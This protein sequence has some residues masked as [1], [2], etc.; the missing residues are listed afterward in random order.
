MTP[1]VTEDCESGSELFSGTSISSIESAIGRKVGS[2]VQDDK[3][4]MAAEFEHS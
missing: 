2:D 3:V 1:P 4:R